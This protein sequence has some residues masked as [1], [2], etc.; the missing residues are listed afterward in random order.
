MS[1]AL[2]GIL[3]TLAGTLIGFVTSEIQEKNR[4]KRSLEVR[5]DE[6]RRNLYANYISTANT[7][8]GKVEWA[9]RDQES[10][11]QERP[12]VVSEDFRLLGDHDNAAMVESIH[13]IGSSDVVQAA[14]QLLL[15]LW[16]AKEFVINGGGRSN[17]EMQRLIDDFVSVRARF[18]LAARSELGIDP[19]N[20]LK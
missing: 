13:L 14:Q 17:P 10:A 3:G 9:A 7:N 2:I 1:N 11:T 5:W 18:I 4:W 8:L 20:L 19:L 16:A 15:S 6:A 12:F